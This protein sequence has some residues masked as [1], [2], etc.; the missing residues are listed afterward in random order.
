MSNITVRS[1]DFARGEAEYVEVFPGQKIKRKIAG[2]SITLKLH[3]SERNP[4]AGFLLLGRDGETVEKISLSHIQS[5]EITGTET[6]RRFRWKSKLGGAIVGIA[7]G[8]ATGGIGGIIAALAVALYLREATKN[9][10]FSVTLYD[11]RCFQATT[12]TQ[13]FVRIFMENCLSAQKMPMLFSGSKALDFSS[14]IK[15]LLGNKRADLVQTGASR[16]DEAFEKEIEILD[17]PS[18]EKSSRL[19]SVLR[20][21][22]E[23]I[24]EK[25][26]A[27]R[28]STIWKKSGAG[29]AATTPAPR[30]EEVPAPTMEPEI[31]PQ[32]LA[33]RLEWYPGSA[34]R[35]VGKAAALPEELRTPIEAIW[36]S[37]DKILSCMQTDPDD[38]KA[39][40]KF[41]SL[42]LKAAHQVI[43]D[44]I[45]LS[46]QGAGYQNVD[47][48]LQKGISLLQRLAAAFEAEHNA[49]LK[50][51][52]LDSSV[53]LEV[54][55][56]TLKMEGR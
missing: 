29:T 18:K 16:L 13:S 38:T 55:D 28:A 8:L 11:R 37:T 15:R 56:R 31:A 51:D 45:H 34:L 40:D 22:E 1:G 44:H 41:L 12:D 50:N 49:L 7:V 48:V 20:R 52:I 53:R 4:F 42:Y 32:E 6:V 36:K 47:E 35:L 17:K 30:Q 39:G 25:L 2:E 23:A 19:P 26:A 24:Q 43:D 10:N 21:S 54:L 33:A 3:S 9:I 14:T 27:A 5:V 46:K